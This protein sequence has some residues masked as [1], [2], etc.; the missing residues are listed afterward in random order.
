MSASRLRKSFRYP[1]D[2]GGSDSDP[3]L[4]EQS[5]EELITT[6]QARDA[7]TNDF[8]R[9]AFLPLP[10]LSA[11]VYLPVI[12]GPKSPRHVLLSFLSLSALGGAAYIL[13]YVP[14]PHEI[15]PK[16]KR[17]MYAAADARGPVDKYLASLV[18]LLSAVVALAAVVAWRKGFVD[19]AWRG[20]LP[21]AIF[22]IV[23]FARSQMAP[24]DV[25]GL[26]RLKY[27]Y[28]GA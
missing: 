25:Q 9:R 27:N 13:Y 6:L 8:Y 10:L 1:A 3:E 15:D 21:G 11:L 14:L 20:V 16:G 23:M 2:D 18:A 19:E 17:P 4:D 28:K 24:L 5:Q 7:S 26:E 22:L 12:F